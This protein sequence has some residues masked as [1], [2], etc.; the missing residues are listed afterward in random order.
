[1]CS[2]FLFF[3]HLPHPV[4]QEVRSPAGRSQRGGHELHHSG[5]NGECPHPQSQPKD[6]Q[7]QFTRFAGVDLAFWV[8]VVGLTG[9]N[10][11]YIIY[12]A[13]GFLPCTDC[14][15]KGEFE[16]QLPNHSL[17]LSRSPRCRWWAPL[18]SWWLLLWRC[19][20]AWTPR[21]GRTTRQRGTRFSTRVSALKVVCQ[22]SGLLVPGDTWRPVWVH[23]Q[24]NAGREEQGEGGWWRGQSELGD[25]VYLLCTRHTA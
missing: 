13:Q 11:Y 20:R 3:S 15:T 14:I 2:F 21:L 17:L 1:M 10:Q 23:F 16:R 18:A 24:S 25:S 7:L 9:T 19:T 6:P 22:S 12:M 5:E 8:H 4:R